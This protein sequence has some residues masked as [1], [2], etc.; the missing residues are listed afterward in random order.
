MTDFLFR[1]AGLLPDAELPGFG[2]LKDLAVDQVEAWVTDAR[3]EDPK[4][5]SEALPFHAV[6]GER[7]DSVALV[8]IYDAARSEAFTNRG[9][10]LVA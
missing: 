9:V 7:I 1:G 5:A 3:E 8:T 2:I 4:D 6:I 10:G